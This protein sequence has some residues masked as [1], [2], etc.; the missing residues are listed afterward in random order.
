MEYWSVEILKN[1][2]V[3]LLNHWNVEILNLWNVESLK[4]WNSKILKLLEYWNRWNVKTLNHRNVEK[5]NLF[6]WLVEMW[7]NWNL[8]NG[9]SNGKVLLQVM[10]GSTEFKW[11]PFAMLLIINTSNR[12]KDIS[13]SSISSILIFNNGLIRITNSL[14]TTLF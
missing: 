2:L 7:L 3:K 9:H 12:I 1:K 4:Y 11:N 14:H 5:I 6:Y 13:I 10:N 8:S